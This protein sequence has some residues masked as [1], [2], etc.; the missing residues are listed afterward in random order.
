MSGIPTAK[1]ELQSLRRGILHPRVLGFAL[2]RLWIYLL[3][4]S[5]LPLL[6]F[7]PS[8]LFFPN[9]VQPSSL[10]VL[11]VALFLFGLNHRMINL[12]HR[13]GRYIGPILA[14]I[15]TVA[16]ILTFSL[17][18]STPLVVICALLTGIGSALLLL[19][20]GS[21]YSKVGSKRAAID[22]SMGYLLAA[23]LYPLFC[24]LPSAMVFV[25]VSFL[26]L[27]AAIVLHREKDG[28]ESDSYTNR[29][30]ASVNRASRKIK[31]LALLRL[32]ISG[33]IFGVA[34]GCMS[35]M[36]ANVGTDSYRDEFTLLFT[37]AIVAAPLFT[38]ICALVSKNTRL[39]FIYR[40]VLLFAAIGFLSVP[41][42]GADRPIPVI[43]LIT[44]YTLFE[45]MIWVILSE[46]AHRFIYPPI[47]V[48]GLGIALTR[49]A[50][51]I[52]GFLL[53]HVLFL[54]RNPDQIPFLELSLVMILAL[55][56]AY[57]FVFTEKDI[58]TYNSDVLLP[59]DNGRSPKIP[60]KQ[61]CSIIG[62]H[63]G[64]TRRETEIFRLL[65]LGRNAARIREELV[66]SEGTSNFHLR[67]VY[68][69]LGV[70][71]H[72]EVIDLIQHTDITDLT[73]KED[74]SR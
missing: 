65:A 51:L 55:V 54:G 47:A 18:P 13:L 20:F 48:F 26:P 39:E 38:L 9:L 5:N 23:L 44:G 56:I 45:L 27:S 72:Q 25:V 34:T 66:I 69:K 53:S 59:H 67:N 50:G 49:G 4:Y 37:V 46:M 21:A 42:L 32:S 35:E 64:L 12:D 30:A 6:A 14:S 63:Y 8:Q 40:P 58:E 29:Y 7:Q 28:R 61:K 52:I 22:I 2:N 74:T 73:G 10:A 31:P 68:Q 19:D 3:F 43:F 16:T 11:S 70:H 60:L 62:K 1:A 24:L 33:L 57:L 17:F 41:I 15:G 71:S 36:Y